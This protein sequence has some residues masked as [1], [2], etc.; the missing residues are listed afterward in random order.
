M[1]NAHGQLDW[2]I[3]P[4]CLVAW[5]CLRASS[6]LSQRT[7]DSL[8]NHTCRYVDY[9]MDV[10]MYFI[11]RDGQY[12]NALGQSWRDFMNGKLAALPGEARFPLTGFT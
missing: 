10:P 7:A 2:L 8:Y 6:P 1:V 4:V 5:I 12:V 11:Y 3:S 9:V